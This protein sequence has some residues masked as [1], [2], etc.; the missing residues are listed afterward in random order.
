MNSTLK[1]RLTAIGL[2]LFACAPFVS[3]QDGGA[4]PPPPPPASGGSDAGSE[5]PPPPRRGRGGRDMLAPLLAQVSN[6]TDDQ[7]AKIAAIQQDVRGKGRAIREDDSLSNEDRR[8]KIMDLMKSTND[9][10][11]AILT[12]DQQKQWDA[13]VASAPRRG[14]GRRGGGEGAGAPPADAPPPP[15][16]PPPAQ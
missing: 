10:V 11:R 13:A 9:Q 6:L 16:P 12:P 2:A 4:T 7:K 1:T 5:T 15:P 14:G 3:A 8:K